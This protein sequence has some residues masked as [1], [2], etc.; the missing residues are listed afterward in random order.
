MTSETAIRLASI[1]PLA[2]HLVTRMKYREAAELLRNDAAEVY[3]T[4]ALSGALKQWASFDEDAVE[5]YIAEV[6]LSPNVVEAYQRRLAN[7]PIRVK[8][9]PAAPGTP[10][11]AQEIQP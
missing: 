8:R 3:R 5:A 1:V 2:N 10:N 4:Q 6:E 9:R 7:N 11:P